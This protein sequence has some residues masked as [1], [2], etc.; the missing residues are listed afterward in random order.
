MGGHRLHA[1]LAVHGHQV[2]LI[3]KSEEIGPNLEAGNKFH[4][5]K[6]IH[7]YGIEVHTGLSVESVIPGGVKT[8]KSNDV[9]VFS[10]FDTVIYVDRLHPDNHLLDSCAGFVN[11]II[12]VG[13]SNKVGDGGSAIQS[14]YEAGLKV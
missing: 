7:N 12:V 2:T 11:E 5:M 6:L 3:T 14:G 9:K 13:D 8:V 1:H 10:G 4:M